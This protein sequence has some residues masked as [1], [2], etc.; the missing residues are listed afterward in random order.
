MYVPSASLRW[1][2]CLLALLVSYA[3]SAESLRVKPAKPAWLPWFGVPAQPVFEDYAP[4]ARSEFLGDRAAIRKAASDPSRAEAAAAAHASGEPPRWS[5]RPTRHKWQP[6]WPSPSR[7]VVGSVAPRRSERSR[8]RR[9]APQRHYRLGTSES[10]QLAHL[11][12]A[13]AAEKPTP[14]SCAHVARRHLGR[15]TFDLDA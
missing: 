7:G 11:V 3:A 13:V 5:R 4:Q 12:G 6:R 8:G 9:L 15:I 14:M 2:A 10:N 1:L